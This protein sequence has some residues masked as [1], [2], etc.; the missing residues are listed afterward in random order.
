VENNCFP[1]DTTY[2]IKLRD[3]AATDLRYLYW[4]LQSLDLPSLRGGAGIPGLNRKDVYE[5]HQIP[6]PPI[7]VQREIVAEIEGY[8]DEIALLKA[9]IQSREVA[10]EGVIAKVWSGD[11][12][13][14]AT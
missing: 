10:I 2:Y 5:K 7:E 1:I 14:S 4:V 6:V 9:E 12:E 8:Q 3:P 11:Q 13:G